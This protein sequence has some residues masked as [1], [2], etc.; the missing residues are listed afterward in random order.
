MET[1]LLARKGT[2]YFLMLSTVAVLMLGPMIKTAEGIPVFDAGNFYANMNTYYQTIEQ[3]R[4]AYQQL[5]T[6]YSQLRAAESQ[7]NAMTSQNYWQQYLTQRP[8]W[9]PR[10]SDE[11]QQM[12]EAGYNPGDQGDVNKFNE[13]KQRYDNKYPALTQA[14]VSKSASGRGWVTYDE[15]RKSTVTS[16]AMSDALHDQQMA[17]YQ[18]YLAENRDRLGATE[19]LKSSMDLTNAM[20]QQ[21]M[22]MQLD[23]LRIAN[24]TLRMAAL[25]S[26]DRLT[27]MALNAEFS[28]KR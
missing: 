7:L 8:G 21:S 16:L 17:E 27:T 28:R 13:A 25:D 5:D 19:D 18:D 24:Q 14:Q 9:L 12:I 26:N 1:T 3:V 10:T 22:L 23:Q 4:A 2:H 6:L 20:L 15:T 11:T